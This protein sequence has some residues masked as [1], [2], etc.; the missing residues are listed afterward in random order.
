MS[1][2]LV[3]HR[4]TNNYLPGPTYSVPQGFLRE[5]EK[6]FP[7]YRIRWSFKKRCWLIEQKCGRSALSPIHIDAH[8]DQLIRAKDGFWSVM[9]IQPGDRMPCPQCGC[10][11]PVPVMRFGETRCEWCMLKGKDGRVVAGFMPFGSALLEHLRRTDPLRDGIKRLAQEAD[12]QNQRRLDAVRRQTSNTIEATTKD[13]FNK[14]VGI[15]SFGYTG[16][17][18]NIHLTKGI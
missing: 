14:L 5:F 8:D 18:K 2:I 9:E 15:S 1:F 16:R 6:E 17:S 11:L 3:R 10:E 4:M 12:E 7:A 13:A